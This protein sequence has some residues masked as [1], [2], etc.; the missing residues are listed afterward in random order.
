M[1]RIALLLLLTCTLVARPAPAAPDDAFGDV[2]PNLLLE[3]VTVQGAEVDLNE[4]TRVLGLRT[5]DAVDQQDLLDAVER[6]RESDLFAEVEFFVRP[7][8]ERGRVELVLEVVARESRTAQVD[9]RLG[10]GVSDVD[11]WY[12]IPAEM[13]FRDVLDDLDSLN[14]RFVLGYRRSGLELA[15]VQRDVLGS[16]SWLG[17]RAAALNVTRVYFHDGLEIGHEV[18]RHR[19]SVA[20]GRAFGRGWNMQ[21]ELGREIVDPKDGAE[22]YQTD[23][24]RDVSDGDDVPLAE[25]PDAISGAVD[26]R[27]TSFAEASLVYTAL[28]AREIAHTPA[29]GVRGRMFWRSSTYRSGDHGL[30]GASLKVFREGLGGVLGFKAQGVAALSD[31]PFYDRPYLGGFYTVRGV[32]SQS[33]TRPEGAEWLWSGSLEYRAPLTDDTEHPGLAAVLFL[34]AG[35]CDGLVAPRGE[36]VAVGAGWGLR[37]H[38]FGLLMGLDVGYPLTGSPVDESFHA[39]A[40]VGWT[41]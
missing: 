1:R 34:D 23:T 3:T 24:A 38:T 31:A 12:A 9:V 29:S 15:Y 7:G 36:P 25:L 26:R 30:G 5:G 35:R 32:P 13:G 40:S 2:F 8:S 4:L 28:S 6:L 33:L 22:I 27:N 20:A 14:L 17:V 18:G 11:G 16:R 37:V 19:L 41:F 39:N 21:L 10:T